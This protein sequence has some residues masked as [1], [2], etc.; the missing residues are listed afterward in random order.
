MATVPIAAESSGPA[1]GRATRLDVP[2][3]CTLEPGAMPDRLV[4]WDAVL[5]FAHRRTIVDGGVRVELDPAVD[6]G[7]VA[8]LMA[9]EQRCCA[10]FAFALT[11]DD[12]GVALEVRAPEAAGT[13]LADLFGTAALSRRDTLAVVAAACA[14]CCIGPMIGVIGALAAGGAATFLI[15]AAAL[16]L[17]AAAAVE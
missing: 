7:E 16:I 1:S 12:R 13:I 14:A 5:A 9:A 17:A 10:F 6:V 15:G 3:A 2:I 11:V 4:E 8:R